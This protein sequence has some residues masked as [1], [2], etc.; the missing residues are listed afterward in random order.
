[1]NKSLNPFS[2]ILPGLIIVSLIAG[3]LTGCGGGGSNELPVNVDSVRNHVISLSEAIALTKRFRSTTDSLSVK[4]PF[5]RDSLQISHSEAFN[6]DSYNLLLNAKDSTGTPA[7]G[8]RTYFGID[9]S[10]VLKLVMVPYDKNGND[11]LKHLISIDQKPVPGAN[12]AKT[13]SLSVEGAQAMEQGQLCPPNCPPPPAS[14]L[15]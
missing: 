3:M 12:S 10:G 13:E 11:I 7:A 6:R 15:N 4:C 5:V 9:P 14:P 1:M 8:I 2:R